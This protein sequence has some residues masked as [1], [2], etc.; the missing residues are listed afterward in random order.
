MPSPPAKAG[1]G[2]LLTDPPEIDPARLGGLDARSSGDL[3]PPLPYSLTCCN[4]FPVHL[5]MKIK[6][7][8][9]DS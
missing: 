5:G 9:S 7:A 1:F 4:R 8:K 3:D 2:D 6:L